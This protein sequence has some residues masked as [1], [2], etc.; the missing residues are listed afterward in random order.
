[1]LIIERC[2][3]NDQIASLIVYLLLI[4]RL[5]TPSIQYVGSLCISFAGAHSPK[6]VSQKVILSA[7]SLSASPSAA[8]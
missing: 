4:L 6:L 3:H 7:L 2:F 5:W 8:S 1:M